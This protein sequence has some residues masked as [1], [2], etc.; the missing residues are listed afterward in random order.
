MP[1]RN[2]GDRMDILCHFFEVADM[3]KGREYGKCIPQPAGAVIPGPATL[4]IFRETGGAG[5]DDSAGIFILMNL[6]HKRRADNFPLMKFS[7]GGMLYPFPPILDSF[8]QKI[9][10]STLQR[11]LQRRSEEHTYELQSLL[12]ISYAVFCLK[13]TKKHY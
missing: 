6:Q 10:S 3:V 13:I 2:I 12:S 4:I 9:F 5:S 8:H 11:R 1:E 7:N